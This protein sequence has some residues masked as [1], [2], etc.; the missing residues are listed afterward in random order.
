MT[1]TKWIPRQSLLNVED[2]FDSFLKNLYPT[3][4]ASF[5][6]LMPNVDIEELEK[7]FHIVAEL[8]G[9][10]KE[11]VHIQLEDNIL[12]V[13]GEKKRENETD[14]K[15]IHRSE[16]SFGNFQRTFRLPEQTDQST[17]QADFKDGILNIVIP[18]KEAVLP[19]QIEINVK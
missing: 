18:K 13:T 3:Y 15:N 1:M 7:E 6:A 16:R 17:I 11:D 14:K 5:C 19:K 4:D 9:V 10:K 2:D 8:P 12:T